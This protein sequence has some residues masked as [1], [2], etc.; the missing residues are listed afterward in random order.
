MLLQEKEQQLAKTLKQIE[1]LKL[2]HSQELYILKL[3]EKK[4]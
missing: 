4:Q 2:Q 1:N 3:K